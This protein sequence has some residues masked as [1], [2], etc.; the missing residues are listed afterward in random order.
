MLRYLA[1][2]VADIGCYAQIIFLTEMHVITD[3][4]NY[5]LLVQD[6]IS[7]IHYHW[8]DDWQT[9]ETSNMCTLPL[10]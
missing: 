4:I 7:G 8:I 1:E 10:T 3:Q 5:W 2:V 6:V 9:E